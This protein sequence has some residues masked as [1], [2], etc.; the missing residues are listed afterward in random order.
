MFSDGTP[1]SGFSLT[2][3][4]KRSAGRSSTSGRRGRGRATVEDD[5]T[6]ELLVRTEGGPYRVSISER[7]EAT[8]EGIPAGSSDVDFVLEPTRRVRMRVLDEESR[9]RPTEFTVAWWLPGEQR[10]SFLFT[11]HAMIA[12]DAE[13]W[14]NLD[15]PDR[16]IDL[17]IG[18]NDEGYVPVFKKAIATGTLEAPTSLEVRLR[19]GLVADFKA[20]A[21]H[22]RL[23]ALPTDTW[24]V[25][26]EEEFAADI[27]TSPTTP[28]Q[29]S[30]LN[31]SGGERFPDR[32][33]RH[34]RLQFDEKG[35]ARIRGLSPGS[36]VLL[37]FPPIH[38]LEPA[39]I[40]LT[41]ERVEPIEVS[42]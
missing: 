40:E 18:A 19:K 14:F 8:K 3:R 26:V 37:S 5:G 42:W 39:R 10:Y 9:S 4:T 33:L 30:R 23:A 24:I 41:E 16:Q 38:G 2:A 21:P 27:R 31:L 36:Y 35:L 22:E 7:S 29:G 6:Y 12:F 32:T 28:T 20:T 13:G 15:V 17:W 11:S 34:R 25:C 1:A